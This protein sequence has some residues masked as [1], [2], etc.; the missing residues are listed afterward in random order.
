MK[1]TEQWIAQQRHIL[2]DCEWQHI[3]LTMPHLL[4][5]SSITTQPLLNQLFRA[6]TVPRSNT[7]DTSASKSAFC[8]LH[9]YGASLINIRIFI[10]R[11]PTVASP[12]MTPRNR[13]SLKRKR[14]KRSGAV[15]SFGSFGMPMVNCSQKHYRISDTSGITRRGVVISTPSFSAIGNSILLKTRVAWHNMKYLGRLLKTSLS[16]LLN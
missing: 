15:P 11:S 2:P 16:R 4:W 9:T 5:P 10:Y 14:S 12:N 13:F 6:D 3:T 7:H 8:A 1:A